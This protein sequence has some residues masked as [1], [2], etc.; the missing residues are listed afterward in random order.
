[1]EYPIK[2]TVLKFSDNL[3]TIKAIEDAKKKSFMAIVAGSYSTTGVCI[4][5]FEDMAEVLGIAYARAQIGRPQHECVKELTDFISEN[6][7]YIEV[8]QMY[9]KLLISLQY[10]GKSDEEI[11]EI[12][13]GN[14]QRAEAIRKNFAPRK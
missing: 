6:M 10:S 11:A 13:Q 3:G 7:S 8:F 5:R 12:I 2:G 1:M 4:A 14:V 9:D